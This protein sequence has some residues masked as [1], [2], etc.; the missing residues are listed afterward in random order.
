MQ[1]AALAWAQGKIVEVIG[2]G[3][4]EWAPMIKVGGGGGEWSP[5]VFTVSDGRYRFRLAPEPP[6]KKWRPWTAEEVPVGAMVSHKFDTQ[7]AERSLITHCNGSMLWTGF[8]PGIPRE[9]LKALEKWDHS[10]DHGKTWLPCGV[11]VTE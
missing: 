10:T 6:E 1:E 7:R 4:M 2:P 11:E 5:G 9:M 8:E 3:F